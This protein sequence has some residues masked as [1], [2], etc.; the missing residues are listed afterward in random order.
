M[1]TFTAHRNIAAVH[2]SFPAGST[3][4]GPNERFPVDITASL[5]LRRWKEHSHQQTATASEHAASSPHGPGTFSSFAQG[6]S[7]SSADEGYSLVGEKSSSP[8]IHSDFLRPPEQREIDPSSL[9]G[10]SL[11]ATL[12]EPGSIMAYGYAP[13]L[14]QQPLLD[15][16]IERFFSSVPF[17]THVFFLPQKNCVLTSWQSTYSSWVFLHSPN[18]QPYRT[19]LPLHCPPPRHLRS[20]RHPLANCDSGANARSISWPCP[21]NLCERGRHGYGTGDVE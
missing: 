10:Q 9:F 20:G 21:Q 5:T 8:T 11:N 4:Q 2:I 1:R 6:L 15:H 17:A 12:N 18:E 14:P 7:G 13:T 19:Q 3:S 16:L